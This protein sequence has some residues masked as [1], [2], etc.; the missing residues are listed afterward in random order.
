LLFDIQKSVLTETEGKEVFSSEIIDF[1]VKKVPI[2]MGEDYVGENLPILPDPSHR[3][4]S[5]PSSETPL[6]LWFQTIT[7]SS[8]ISHGP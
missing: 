8:F 6:F 5:F 3:R 4:R 7:V 2:S 1:G